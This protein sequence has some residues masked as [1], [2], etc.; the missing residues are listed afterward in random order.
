MGLI[1][2]DLEKLSTK[3]TSWRLQKKNQTNSDLCGKEGYFFV[4]YHI[5]NCYKQ[6]LF[7]LLFFKANL[8]F[9]L[10]FHRTISFIFCFMNSSYFRTYINKGSIQDIQ[11]TSCLSKFKFSLF[12]LLLESV[13]STCFP[14]QNVHMICIN[15][16]CCGK[17]SHGAKIS[18]VCTQSQLRTSKPHLFW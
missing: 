15:C 16:P 17:E 14:F 12:C 7:C 8:N 10:F 18:G 13:F 3:A 6:L 2:Y 4:P 9:S 11:D 5:W 1:F